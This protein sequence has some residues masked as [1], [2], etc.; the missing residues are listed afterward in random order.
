M[1]KAVAPV[2]LTVDV[3]GATSLPQSP[4]HHI[5]VDVNGGQVADETFDGQVAQLIEATLSSGTLVEGDNTVTVRLPHDTGAQFDLQYLD[6]YGVTYPREFIAKDNQLI[7]EATG[8]VFAVQGFSTK[9]IDVYKIDATGK[10]TRF[11]TKDQ[12]AR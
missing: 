5:V 3:S 11:K 2:T 4:D 7:F 10:A 8:E 6:S 9:P 12:E 1:S